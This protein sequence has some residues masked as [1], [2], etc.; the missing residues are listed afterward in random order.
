MDEDKLS[1]TD[2]N[3]QNFENKVTEMRNQ[4]YQLQERKLNSGQEQPS[5]QR[6]NKLIEAKVSVQDF[7]SLIVVQDEAE[8]D[9][10]LQEVTRNN[11][12][13]PK[14][15]DS[16][17]LYKAYF[18][19]A[20]NAYDR[21]KQLCQLDAVRISL[22]GMY[23]RKG[24][25]RE[26]I[27]QQSNQSQK[28]LSQASSQIF[29]SELT[30]N[31][32]FPL[33]T[34]IE[35]IREFFQTFAEQVEEFGAPAALRSIV[36][37]VESI[38]LEYAQALVM[39]ISQLPDFN[40]TP[41]GDVIQALD[42]FTA[43]Y[44]S[45]FGRWTLTM[46]NSTNYDTLNLDV[47][48]LYKP[49]I[50]RVQ[51]S[52]ISA[53][54]DPTA[55][56]SEF[57]HTIETLYDFG[58]RRLSH[59]SKL[60][61][62]IQA[63]SAV[64]GT[65]L[66][67]IQDYQLASIVDY[68]IGYAEKYQETKIDIITILQFFFEKI[69][70]NF[71]EIMFELPQNWFY[72]FDDLVSVYYYLSSHIDHEQ[73][74][75]V[76]TAD[77]VI[78][79]QK[80][81]SANGGSQAIVIDQ[82]IRHAT[83]DRAKA[84]RSDC[85]DYEFSMH[86]ADVLKLLQLLQTQHTSGS[87]IA[88]FIACFAKKNNQQ[89]VL[90]Y[91]GLNKDKL[92]KQE[93]HWIAEGIAGSLIGQ[94]KPSELTETIEKL[95]DQLKVKTG[96]E[97]YKLALLTDYRSVTSRSLRLQHI[98]ENSSILEGLNY[99]MYSLPTS[100]VTQGLMLTKS[101]GGDPQMEVLEREAK[102]VDAV[103]ADARKHALKMQQIANELESLGARPQENI[104]SNLD[105]LRKQQAYTKI[106][107]N[108]FTSEEE[109]LLERMGKDIIKPMAVYKS[110]SEATNAGKSAKQLDNFK[111]LI[112]LNLAIR[113]LKKQ[114]SNI[115]KVAIINVYRSF[116]G[117]T[118]YAKI[119][120]DSGSNVTV[121]ELQIGEQLVQIKSKDVDHFSEA[122]KYVQRLE[123]K[124]K[125]PVVEDGAKPSE[126]GVAKEVDASTQE[127]QVVE[128]AAKPKD[129]SEVN[130]ERY[131]SSRI[132]VS[133]TTLK[134]LEEAVL[135][136]HL[137]RSD[138][139][140]RQLLTPEQAQEMGPRIRTLRALRQT[141]KDTVTLQTALY[142]I[143]ASQQYMQYPSILDALD[144][145][146]VT[147]VLGVLK[148]LGKTKTLLSPGLVAG[149]MEKIESVNERLNE[150]NYNQYEDS[151]VENIFRNLPINTKRLLAEEYNVASEKALIRLKKSLE[152]AFGVGVAK[153]VSVP[154][155]RFSSKYARKDSLTERDV[156]ELAKRPAK[157]NLD[158]KIQSAANEITNI[159]KASEEY[160][161]KEAN[162]L[163]LL[164][165]RE[166]QS[167][168]KL[169][170]TSEEETKI[171]KRSKS[172]TAEDAKSTTSAHKEDQITAD[173]K[174]ASVQVSGKEV[175]DDIVD[176]ETQSTS[177]SFDAEKA[178]ARLRHLLSRVFT[179]ASGDSQAVKEAYYRDL[180]SVESEYIRK[181]KQINEQ[182]RMDSYFADP[183]NQTLKRYN[184]TQ[185][186]Q[187][188]V[189]ANRPEAVVDQFN[190]RALKAR[191]TINR[192][193]DEDQAALTLLT[194]DV[195][196]IRQIKLNKQESQTI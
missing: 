49:F 89:E 8:F 13:S 182:R 98:V 171:V 34:P 106:F 28:S 149:I 159:S 178:K 107:N 3:L 96:V 7:F 188:E 82:L 63:I 151:I 146:P 1:N 61:S 37:Q 26:Y 122:E 147:D 170:F 20:V 190:K 134:R 72:S 164:R 87:V 69:T 85:L 67:D 118:P 57:I 187:M 17:K 131:T 192:L 33:Q 194:S 71:N 50:Q 111:S 54:T 83:S 129:E 48:P 125:Q 55:F 109:G 14:S 29:Y 22:S 99:D 62:G 108:Q 123:S 58:V 9:L 103:Q 53:D 139:A 148:T 155:G 144:I 135:L 45:D 2:G 133:P 84:V 92:E 185:L 24:L 174:S 35:D 156:I 91:L 32:T 172:A 119:Q 56:A 143:N 180:A 59:F 186:E 42:V 76:L 51:S 80:L 105:F 126:A 175:T 124:A 120:T 142:G 121:G 183:R 23:V 66:P 162:L 74:R 19:E 90:C 46:L 127:G 181:Q 165:L 47:S 158:Q 73:R 161:G 40:F 78:A 195:K 44:G 30:Q 112:E 21:E 193:D 70:L 10:K 16:C 79:I 169:D 177:D 12:T 39:Y 38:H 36:A 140:I 65:S 68:M 137:L 15:A 31:A 43:V 18:E 102:I 163:S 167:V 104:D 52:I 184:Q 101:K 100:V 152:L 128:D 25:I 94:I 157:T 160:P 166:S 154:D 168:Q 116:F 145:D 176:E 75:V 153:I 60:D 4:Y 117:L 191:N 173:T 130:S 6:L 11:L 97:A 196:E 27:N 141:V 189:A 64:S 132:V 150:F 86:E 93:R 95:R 81:A 41:K 114:N 88:S 179:L 115:S 136:K 77:S 110:E 138:E 5:I 113:G